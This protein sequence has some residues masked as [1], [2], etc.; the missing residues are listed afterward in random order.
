MQI[1]SKYHLVD[2][3][4]FLA[5]NYT[6][7]SQLFPISQFWA[8]Y[9]TYSQKTNL[10]ASVLKVLFITILFYSSSPKVTKDKVSPYT[11]S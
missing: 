8:S 10:L 1:W 6:L 9:N 2:L 5:K 3:C 7:S 11:P 4:V